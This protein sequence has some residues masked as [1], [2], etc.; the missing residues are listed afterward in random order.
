MPWWGKGVGAAF[1]WLAAGPWGAALGLALGNSADRGARPGRRRSPGLLASVGWL[2]PLFGL[3]G[4]LA[5]ADGRVSE[6]E[7]AFAHEFMERM[8]LDRRNRG[9]AARAFN[10]GRK[11][12]YRVDPA[13]VRLRAVALGRPDLAEG[14]LSVLVAL[15]GVDGEPGPDAERL[16]RKAAM[17][18]GTGTERLDRMR[19]ATPV[20][21][22]DDLDQAY[23]T[24]G[25][26]RRASDR[27]V[28]L[29]YRRL[30][31]R[32][33]PDRLEAGATP[34][35]VEIA[36]RRT[37]SVRRAYEQVRESRDSE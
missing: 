14:L 13:L 7:V 36:V 28:K 18:L 15:A 26:D 27:E 33:H 29:A 8:R 21:A 1:G 25:I 32:H 4:A 3:M 6:A 30:M 10:A 37:V 16:L 35:T 9:R 2:T 22:T 20:Q 17:L 31:H 19:H 34:E 24:L 12:G 23:A 11:P 5:R